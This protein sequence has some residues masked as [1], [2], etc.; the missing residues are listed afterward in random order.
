M[1]VILIHGNNKLILC[2][3]VPDDARA[4]ALARRWCLSRSGRFSGSEAIT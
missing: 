3:P 2:G 4:L 1:V